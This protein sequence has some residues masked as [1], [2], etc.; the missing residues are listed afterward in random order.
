M[1]F[2]FSNESSLFALV[3]GCQSGDFKRVQ[4]VIST[5]LDFGLDLG[6]KNSVTNQHLQH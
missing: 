6:K 5:F 4:L 2:D 3:F 1:N